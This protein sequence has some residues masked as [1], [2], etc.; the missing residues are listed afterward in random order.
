MVTPEHLYR[1]SRV[2]Y[3]IFAYYFAEI[4]AMTVAIFIAII[5]R[6]IYNI[7]L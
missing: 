3:P 2:F 7:L 4:I 1:E 5:A 6:Y